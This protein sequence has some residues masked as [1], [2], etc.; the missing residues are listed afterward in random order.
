MIETKDKKASR[1]CA[2]FANEKHAGA[3]STKCA[4]DRYV[5]TTKRHDTTKT[6]TNMLENKVFMVIKQNILPCH[7][8]LQ[9]I[10]SKPYQAG[11][12]T[13]MPPNLVQSKSH[14]TKKET[15]FGSNKCLNIKTR[16]SA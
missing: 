4:H 7:N 9:Q 11:Q 14:S 2:L 15:D 16:H 5:N 10:K 12:N 8:I 1:R 13:T 3:R 6:Y